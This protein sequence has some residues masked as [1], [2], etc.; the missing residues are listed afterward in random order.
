MAQLLISHNLQS[1]L[2]SLTSLD[3]RKS[4]HVFS[5][6]ISVQLDLTKNME[7]PKRFKKEGCLKIHKKSLMLNNYKKCLMC[8]STALQTSLKDIFFEE[9]HQH[10]S[11]PL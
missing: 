11:I 3:T 8:A 7:I 4:Q 5:Q 9:M 1:W 2:R 6:H 10:L